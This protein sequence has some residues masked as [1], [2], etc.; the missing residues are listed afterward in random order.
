MDAQEG[1][2]RTAQPA[3]RGRERCDSNAAV[4]STRSETAPASPDALRRLQSR[5]E[6][7]LDL[8]HSCHPDL[9][10]IGMEELRTALKPVLSI[11]A[12]RAF[13]T[14]LTSRGVV[15]L[16]RMWVRRPG[17]QVEV[18]PEDERLCA[19]ICSHL[20][21]RPYRPPRVRD[22][23][24]A[25]RIDEHHVRQLLH[26]LAQRGDVEEIALDHFFLQP[27]VRVMAGIAIELATQDPLGSFT[28][29]SFRDRLDNGR[30][31]AIQILEFFDRHGF[32][33][34]EQ[35]RR[36]INPDW[37]MLFHTKTGG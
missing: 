24:H 20:T 14:G 18:G 36:R 16:D 33:I 9:P 5:I 1:I 6:T 4:L 17:R 32:T 21:A 10:G 30:K 28:A 11:P 23:A 29:A 8:F 7:K 35:E 2:L 27:T 13:L 26:I 25:E 34:L 31:V 15:V 37:K 19:T 12:F 22:I 3:T